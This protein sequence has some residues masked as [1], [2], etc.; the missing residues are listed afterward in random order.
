MEKGDDPPEFTQVR[1]VVLPQ[2]NDKAYWQGLIVVTDTQCLDKGATSFWLAPKDEELLKLIEHDDQLAC[3]TAE[4][5]TDQAQ[6]YVQREVVDERGPRTLDCRGNTPF[7]GYYR[8]F[9]F[10]IGM[11]GDHSISGA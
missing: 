10:I 1:V 7:D 4:M 11:N 3:I 9:V 5:R 6:E 2:R 8:V